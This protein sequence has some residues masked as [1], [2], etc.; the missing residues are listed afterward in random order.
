M[1]AEFIGKSKHYKKGKVY[2]IQSKLCD[3]IGTKDVKNIIAVYNVDDKS[4]LYKFQKS[5]IVYTRGEDNTDAM[6]SCP[7]RTY[8]SIEE[9]IRDWKVV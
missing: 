8:A 4:A 6:S 9:F 1:R 7:Y 3:A 2:N 5:N